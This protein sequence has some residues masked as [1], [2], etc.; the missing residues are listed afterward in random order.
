MLIAGSRMRRQGGVRTRRI[1]VCASHAELSQVSV[2][3]V[4]ERQIWRVK[5]VWEAVDSCGVEVG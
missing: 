2:G 1:D 5:K 4:W 3:Q